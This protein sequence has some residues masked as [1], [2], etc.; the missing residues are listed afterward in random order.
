MR[1]GAKNDGGYVLLDDFE[2]IKIAY[3]FGVSSEIS[4]DKGLA[5]KNIDVYMYDH[6]IEKLPFSNLKFH[7]KKIGLTEQKGIKS[8][9]FIK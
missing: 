7:W 3:S 5:D 1:I 6:T 9:F 2:N 4:F 8:I